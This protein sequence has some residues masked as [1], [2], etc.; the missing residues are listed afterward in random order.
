MIDPNVVTD[1]Y[2]VIGNPIT[3]SKSPQIH[4][5]FAR[6][7]QQMMDY[8]TIL[9]EIGQFGSQVDQWIASGA[10]G[11]NI[12]APFKR[13]A[14]DYA[15]ELSDAAR[16]AGAVNAM[17][18][19]DGVAYAENF[20]GIGLVNDISQNLGFSF[21]SQRVLILGSGGAARGALQPILK[22]NPASV[23]IACR[24]KDSA[25]A[26]VQTHRSLGSVDAIEYARLCDHQFD[27]VLNA[28]SASLFGQLPPIE[29]NVFSHCQLAYDLTYGKGLTPFLALAQAAQAA[30]LADGVGMLVEQ[31]A[32]AFDWWRGIRPDTQ[33]A[34]T[35]LSVALR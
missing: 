7:T 27:I 25:D 11:L 35:A 18:F 12:T 3:Q 29:I 21:N 8:Q 20:D 17:K 34:I 26:L 6:A 9:G 2:A 32:C 23:V 16:L 24:K 14:F 10:K 31:A 22:T 1:R 33:A 4:G 19:V 30:Q 5:L 28:T 15:D 13:D